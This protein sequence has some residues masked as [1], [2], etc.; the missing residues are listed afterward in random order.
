MTELDVFA[1]FWR[2]WYKWMRQRCNL[3]VLWSNTGRYIS[4]ICTEVFV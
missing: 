1:L 2:T 4:A 3:E